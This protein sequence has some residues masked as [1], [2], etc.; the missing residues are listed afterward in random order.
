MNTNTLH[1]RMSG[2]GADQLA[3]A[4]R[5]LEQMTKWFKDAKEPPQK[6]LQKIVSYFH[7]VDRPVY[8][9]YVSVEVG[10]SLA[11]T[12]DMLH[13][14][15]DAGVVRQLTAQEK[16]ELQIDSRANIWVLVDRAHPAKANW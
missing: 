13:A 5:V 11:Q 10:Y 7:R 9:G 12:E 3:E 15:E 14:L 16:V 4:M 6:A 2:L 1:L 8:L